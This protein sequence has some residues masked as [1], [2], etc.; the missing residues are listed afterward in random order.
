MIGDHEAACD[1]DR[2]AL[3]VLRE[4]AE[5][6]GAAEWHNF[7]GSALNLSEYTTDATEAKEVAAEAVRHLNDFMN[8]GVTDALFTLVNAMY[9]LGIAQQRLGEEDA[10]HQFVDAKHLLKTFR[11]GGPEAAR[12]ADAI[13]AQ[14]TSEERGR[15]WYMTPEVAEASGV[16]LR[17][18]RAT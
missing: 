12:L 11:L 5:I 4:C 8:A 16:W 3:G 10:I 7:F 17:M 13:R 1:C 2:Q 6:L 14:I 18:M 15:G 9:L